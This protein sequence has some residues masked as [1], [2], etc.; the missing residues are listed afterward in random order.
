MKETG[1][2]LVKDVNSTQCVAA[3]SIKLGAAA[4]GKNVGEIL[5]GFLEGGLGQTNSLQKL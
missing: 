3:G 1:S 2:H 4:V 5:I